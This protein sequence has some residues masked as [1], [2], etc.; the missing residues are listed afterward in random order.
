MTIEQNNNLNALLSAWRDHQDNKDRGADISEL[1]NSR[2][3]L[4]TARRETQANLTLAS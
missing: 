2:D 1:F 4:D 3:R